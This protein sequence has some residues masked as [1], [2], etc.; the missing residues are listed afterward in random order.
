MGLLD[1]IMPKQGGGG[2]LLDWIM[3]GPSKNPYSGLLS[4]EMYRMWRRQ[5][6]SH[7]A[8]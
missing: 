7:T 6:M 2:G 5:Q 4:D 3:P 1:M 8:E